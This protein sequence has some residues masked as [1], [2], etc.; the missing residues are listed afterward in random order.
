MSDSGLGQF[1]TFGEAMFSVQNIADYGVTQVKQFEANMKTAIE[2]IK[3]QDA[4]TIDQGTLL[5]LQMNVQNWA[6][7]VAMMTNLM[8]AIGDGMGKVVQ[9]IR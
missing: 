2:A 9:N 4:S 6:T 5:E 3:G 7:L 1:E 8:R